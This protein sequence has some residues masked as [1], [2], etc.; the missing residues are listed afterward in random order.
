MED[1]AKILVLENE[2][3]AKLIEGILKEKEIPHFIRS[4]H[5]TAYDGLFQ[6]L[7]GWGEILAPSSYKEEIEEIVEEIRR[8][9]G[10][11]E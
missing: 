3:E 5:D 1:F 6:V 4:Y 7:T 11:L 9:R 10:E 2:I 8:V